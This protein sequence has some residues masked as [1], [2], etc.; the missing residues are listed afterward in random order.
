RYFW[1]VEAESSSLSTPTK[2]MLLYAVGDQEHFCCQACFIY[3]G[4]I[5]GAAR[6]M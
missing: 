3:E 5:C 6:A 2:Q 4:V 1:E